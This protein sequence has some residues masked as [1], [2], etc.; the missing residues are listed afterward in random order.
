MS[1]I[2]VAEHLSLDGVLQAPGRADEDTSGGFA[3][4]GWAAAGA[5]EEVAGALGDRVARAGGMRLLLGRRS[6]DDMLAYWNTQDSPF[7]DGLNHAEKHVVSRD[8]GTRLPWP[9][10]TLVAGDIVQ[11]VRDLKREP[12]ADL[13]IMGSSELVQTLLQHRLIDELLLFIHPL[14]LGAGKRL[15]APG[16]EPARLEQLACTPTATGVTIA[17]YRVSDRR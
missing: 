6:Y 5:N 12:G 13:C 16:G 17:H 8:P 11:A 15:F 2:Y 3:S 10:S 1:R 14:L 9:K 7:R 4:G